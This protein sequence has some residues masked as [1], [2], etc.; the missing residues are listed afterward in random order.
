M[1]EWR[2][3]DF[4]AAWDDFYKVWASDAVQE[5]VNEWMPFSDSGKHWVPGDD[6]WSYCTSQ[7]HTKR[8]EWKTLDYMYDNDI[9]VTFKKSLTRLGVCKRNDDNVTNSPA[10]NRIIESVM[11][12]HEPVA[13][14]QEANV[15]VTYAR[16]MLGA[17]AI[18]MRAFFPG[19]AFS[20]FKLEE[21]WY[22]LVNIEERVVYD[23]MLQFMYSHG[24]AKFEPNMIS[25]QETLEMNSVIR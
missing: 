8:I 13:K 3:F 10:C 18:A 21:G 23:F 20:I 7:Y 1:T 16:H 19:K 12:D 24:N 4:S 22:F 14:S 17:Q 15:V 11:K 9:F 25:R 6:L 2:Y 5:T